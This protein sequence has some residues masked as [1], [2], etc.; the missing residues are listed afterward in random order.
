MTQAFLGMIGDLVSWSLRSM[1]GLVYGVMDLAGSSD[2]RNFIKDVCW[3]GFEKKTM[4]TN[5]RR[6]KTKENWDD[7]VFTALFG[8]KWTGCNLS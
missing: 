8:I 1:G 4:T 2:V 7:S 6:V 5:R 3:F